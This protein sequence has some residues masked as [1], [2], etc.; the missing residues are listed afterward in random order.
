VIEPIFGADVLS[1]TLHG[2]QTTHNGT[3]P[4]IGTHERD[5]D[6]T[7]NDTATQAWQIGSRLSLIEEECK[8]AA[9]IINGLGDK[10]LW[11]LNYGKGMHQ[12]SYLPECNY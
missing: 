11:F 3:N 8:A 12:P 10:P 9:I 7:R 2:T 1:T 6:G 4:G 5:A